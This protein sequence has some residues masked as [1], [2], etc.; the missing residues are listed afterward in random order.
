[1]VTVLRE[2]GMRFV[3]YTDDHKP[4][5]TQ[6][7]GDGEARMNILDLT[8]ISNRGMKKRDLGVAVA[9]VQANKR[10]FIKKWESIHGRSCL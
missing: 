5:H 9:T 8:V 3:I 4:A 1:M 7:Y 2:A 6:V 10:L